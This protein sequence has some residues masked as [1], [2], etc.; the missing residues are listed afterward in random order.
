VEGNIGKGPLRA[1]LR[2]ILKITTYI[3]I[4]KFLPDPF[5]A[6]NNKALE[7]ILKYDLIHFL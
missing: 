2:Q 7:I 4:Y 6:A 5:L 1:F 3:C